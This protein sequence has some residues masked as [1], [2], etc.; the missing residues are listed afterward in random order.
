MT[1]WLELC[2]LDYR[3]CGGMFRVVS[4]MD[5]MLR[6]VDAYLCNLLQGLE[7]CCVNRIEEMNSHTP[8]MLVFTHFQDDG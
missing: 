3:K 5:D 2:S 7:D 8:M 4:L 6:L 1:M